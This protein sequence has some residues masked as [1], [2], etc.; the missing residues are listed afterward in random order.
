MN[1][2]CTIGNTTIQLRDEKLSISVRANFSS[3]ADSDIQKVFDDFQQAL[4]IIKSAKREYDTK[5]QE[6][7]ASKIEI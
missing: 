6:P 5:K 4:D 3:I 1:L 2:D 7:I